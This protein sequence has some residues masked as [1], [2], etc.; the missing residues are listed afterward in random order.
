MSRRW[1]DL[2]RLVWG[3]QITMD[4]LDQL[5]K[6]IPEMLTDLERLLPAWEL[7]FTGCPLL[8]CYLECSPKQS[9]SKLCVALSTSWNWACTHLGPSYN[10]QKSGCGCIRPQAA[11]HIS[12]G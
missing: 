4:Q 10:N 11:V 1:I 12:R 9:A 5:E 3:K 8:Y 7:D 2:L 6:A